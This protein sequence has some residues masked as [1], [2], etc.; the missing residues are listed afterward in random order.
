MKYFIIEPEVAGGLGEKTK[1]V[2]AEGKIKDITH[3]DY[4]FQGWQGDDILATHPC[5]IISESLSETIKHSSLKG[6]KLEDMDVS[7]SDE[8]KE[9]CK[10]N[11]I[12]QFIRIIPTESIDEIKSIDL[13]NL[14][15]YFY[16]KRYLVISEDALKIIKCFHISNSNISSI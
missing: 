10:V 11:N 7:F 15:F 8:F 14:D 3:L 1:I 13:L 9:F 4:E 5:F 6:Y 2:Y 12:P 16:K